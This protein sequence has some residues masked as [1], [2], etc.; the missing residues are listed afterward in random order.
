MSEVLSDNKEKKKVPQYQ[1]L[2]MWLIERDNWNQHFLLKKTQKT[3]QKPRFNIQKNNYKK[4][5]TKLQNTLWQ[6][7]GY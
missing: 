4:S 2:S 1:F 6:V 5:K 7:N 3:P